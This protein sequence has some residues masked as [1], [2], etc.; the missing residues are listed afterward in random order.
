MLMTGNVQSEDTK[1]TLCVPI[2]VTLTLVLIALA[3]CIYRKII[4]A[5]SELAKKF[6]CN[7]TVK[8]SSDNNISQ[9]YSDTEHAELPYTSL[10][11]TS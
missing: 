9:H 11:V 6:Y 1:C 4:L 5:F 7:C 10:S 3:K 2:H 8:I